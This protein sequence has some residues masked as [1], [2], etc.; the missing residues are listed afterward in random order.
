MP[1]DAGP[2]PLDIAAFH[3]QIET[4]AEALHQHHGARLNCR[5]G[6]CDCC[7]DEL[8]VF[9]VE[10][11]HIR[12]S[13]G[14]R[15][16]GAEPAPAGRCAFL[17]PSGAC[18][19]YAARPYVCRTQGLPLR[20]VE[21]ENWDWVEYR[22]ICPLNEAGPPLETLDEDVCWTLGEAEASLAQLQQNHAP[23]SQER[24][25]LRQLFATLAGDQA[26]G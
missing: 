25:P 10:A 9:T 14:D 22:D 20:W 11:D 19:I 8:T 16:R 1:T 18:R 21:E 7:V 3:R 12:R 15:L 13:V 24:V 23:D 6:C 26:D 17:D 5:R 2:P 4:R